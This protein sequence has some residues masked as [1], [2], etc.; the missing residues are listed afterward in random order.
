MSPARDYYLPS[1][2][3]V[4]QEDSAMI[5]AANVP[6]SRFENNWT[7]KMAFDAGYLVPFMV[8]EI[9]P[10]DHMRYRASVYARLGTTLFP[11]FDNMRI[12]TF[13]FFVP[14]RLIWA[15]WTKF[16]GE[17]ATPASS[18]AFTIPTITSTGLEGYP[19]GSIFD[20][21]GLP[22]Q[23]DAAGDVTNSTLPLRAYNLIYNQWFRDQNI[24]DSLTVETDD[25][26]D[27]MSLYA[28][29]KRAKAHDY[30]TSCLPWAQKFTAPTVPVAGLAPVTGVGVRNPAPTAGPTNVLTN[31]GTV[32]FSDYYASDTV[33]QALVFDGT[34][35]GLLNVYA[36]LSQATGVAINTFRQAFM[37]QSLLERDARGGTRYTE[38]IWSHFKVR[39]PD[40]RLQRPEYIGGGQT[41]LHI[42]PIAQTTEG[43]TDPLGHLGG[44]GTAAGQHTASYAATEHGYIIGIINVR[45]ELSYQQGLPRMWSRS[46]RY[47]FYFPA[48]AGLGEQG[49]LRKE[50]YWTGNPT[51]DNL[52][53]GYQERWHEYRTRYSEVTG[54]MR[55]GETGTLDA[56]HLAE[57]FAT[58]PTLSQTFI[59]D[60]TAEILER[61]LAAGE[62]AAGQ[63]LLADIMIQRSATRPLPIFGTPALLGRF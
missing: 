44:T 56:W 24:I 31:S 33:G 55:S 63:Q 25:G 2:R 26:P 46:T 43:A 52:V 42:T 58:D 38:L 35:G 14:C 45:A 48:F 7:R 8:D 28:L 11:I 19:V 32:A 18:I 20:H 47:D 61:V 5:E 51:L 23:A 49:V 37:V 21:M 53:F 10:G 50:I 16:M 59:E 36:D 54:I 60:Q 22:T 62:E 39:N 30:F 29:Q 4:S 17:Q 40:F 3:L 13:W 6:R 57:F 34:P 9:L 12:D 41:P 1:R 15:N 27:T